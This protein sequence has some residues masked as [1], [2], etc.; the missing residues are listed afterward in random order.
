[1][2]SLTPADLPPVVT[3]SVWL[4]RL[5]AG[6]GLLPGSTLHWPANV[7]FLQI[8]DELQLAPRE[9]TAYA[10]DVRAGDGV[11]PDIYKRPINPVY[12]LYRKGYAGLS[13]EPNLRYN[14]ITEPEDAQQP[15]VAAYSSGSLPAALASANHSGGVQIAWL[16][17]SPRTIAHVLHHHGAP[18]DFEALHLDEDVPLPLL[19]AILAA[20]YT[21]KAIAVRINAD[22]PPPLRWSSNVGRDAFRHGNEAASAGLLGASADALFSLLA[23][24]YSLISF[25]LGRWSRWCQ[26]CDERMWFVRSDLL[27]LR[28]PRSLL[29]WR[30]MLRAYWAHVLASNVAPRVQPGKLLSHSGDRIA[31]EAKKQQ[32]EAVAVSILAWNGTQLMAS[33]VVTFTGEAQPFGHPSAEI[34]AADQQLRGWCIRAERC[35]LHVFSHAPEA[36]VP[37]MGDVA[38]EPIFVS[39]DW[40]WP[41]PSSVGVQTE[42]YARYA[43]ASE[44]G[45][46]PAMSRAVCAYA[47][48]WA[49][50]T[51]EQ[52]CER[53]KDC[54]GPEEVGSFA[55]AVAQAQ[56]SDEQPESIRCGAGTL[57]PTGRR[58][59]L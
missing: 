21:P 23:P 4:M 14:G 33:A 43:V 49:Q 2:P 28:P 40:P 5:L 29:S 50:R 34:P 30:Q 10:V 12:P 6:Q 19:D 42:A 3:G 57:R 35:P 44:K 26:R 56:D 17:P 46:E 48:D 16:E 39:V 1:M 20:N 51:R 31:F 54:K 9:R 18:V 24:R 36:A 8:F 38:D 41:L 59:L 7:S 52:V 22:L 53:S 45:S 47:L 27:G 11:R 25:Q 58:S 37:T 15:S 32:N 13:I 55:L